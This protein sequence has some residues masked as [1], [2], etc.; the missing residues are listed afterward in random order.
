MTKFP[1][2]RATVRQGVRAR[3][4]E[5]RDELTAWIASRVAGPGDETA[6]AVALLEVAVGAH[7]AVMGQTE[8]LA[9]LRQM[10]DRDP[11]TEGEIPH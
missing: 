7:C 9:H 2:A 3:V 4:D 11:P 10:F 1:R 6:C 5:I 8:A